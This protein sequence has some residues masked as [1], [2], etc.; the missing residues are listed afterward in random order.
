MLELIE[1]ELTRIRRM[2][3]QAGDP[4]LLYLIDMAALEANAKARARADAVE[5]VVRG[6]GPQ[7]GPATGIG[8]PPAPRRGGADRSKRRQ[9]IPA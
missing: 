6:E 8:R 7:G 5:P 4:F 3:E 1:I 9:R 2:A